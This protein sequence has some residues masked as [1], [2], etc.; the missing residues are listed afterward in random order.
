MARKKREKEVAHR[1]NPSPALIRLMKGKL[2]G[3]T[4]F[5]TKFKGRNIIVIAG[6]QKKKK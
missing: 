2:P 3:R 1:P 5:G 6:E 4:K